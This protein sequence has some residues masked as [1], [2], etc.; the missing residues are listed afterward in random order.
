VVFSPDGSKLASASSDKTV[1]VWNISTGQIE[2]TLDAEGTSHSVSSVA[3]SPDGSKLALA[4]KSMFKV[5]LD[6]GTWRVEQTLKGYFD[7]VN[8]MVFSPTNSRSHPIYTVD[9]SRR[10][11]AENGSRILYLP[12]DYRSGYIATEGNTLAIGVAAGRVMII[13]F[14]SNAKTGNI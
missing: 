9:I 13:K 11:V 10:W 8:S 14:H 3:F 5:V 6:V 4:L 7:S 12:C 2:M 1:R